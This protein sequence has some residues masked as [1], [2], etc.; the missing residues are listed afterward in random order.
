MWMWTCVCVWIVQYLPSP[1]A[2]LVMSR[3]QT[4]ARAPHWI[5]YWVLWRQIIRWRHFSCIDTLGR[6]STSVARLYAQFAVCLLWIGLST[7]MSIADDETNV[8]FSLFRLF[9]SISIYALI[10][11]IAQK[12]KLNERNAGHCVLVCFRLCGRLERI[13]VTIHIGC[14]C[15]HVLIDACTHANETERNRWECARGTRR[16]ERC[17]GARWAE[18]TA[19]MTFEWKE[20]SK[21]KNKK[22][23]SRIVVTRHGTE[24]MLTYWWFALRFGSVENCEK[25]N[26]NRVNVAK[27]WVIYEWDCGQSASDVKITAENLSKLMKS[28]GEKF[29]LINFFFDGLSHSRSLSLAFRSLCLCVNVRLARFSATFKY[30]RIFQ[31]GSRC[32]CR[33]FSLVSRSCVCGSQARCVCVCACLCEWMNRKKQCTGFGYTL[34]MFESVSECSESPQQYGN[35][36]Q[37][38]IIPEMPSFCICFLCAAKCTRKT[39]LPA[40]STIFFKDGYE[41]ISYVFCGIDWWESTSIEWSERRQQRARKKERESSIV[42]T[43][44]KILAALFDRYQYINRFVVT[45]AILL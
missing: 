26:E 1:F 18:D 16:R 34:T 35:C 39:E 8:C 43:S 28:F 29:D 6:R 42:L 30:A 37:C 22:K 13:R 3:V 7:T 11:A 24:K 20:R 40:S 23:W 2:K 10:K 21:Y 19:H 36:L 45:I 33:A 25:N 31:F 27:K 9:D 12:N 5:Q 44:F 32:L 38:V 41:R 4:S 14:A 17:T 15:M